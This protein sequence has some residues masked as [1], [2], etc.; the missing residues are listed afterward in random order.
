MLQ[1]IGSIL[2]FYNKLV[3]SQNAFRKVFWM[4]VR[5]EL[6]HREGEKV[7]KNLEFEVAAGLGTSVQIRLWKVFM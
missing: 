6:L 1:F 3:H 4:V 2:L 7:G 5:V